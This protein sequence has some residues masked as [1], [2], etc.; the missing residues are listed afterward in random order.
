[1]ASGLKVVARAAT[2]ALSAFLEVPAI[3]AKLAVASA[4]NVVARAA[5]EALSALLA[6]PAVKANEAV[7]V[8]AKA[9]ALVATEAVTSTVSGRFNVTLTSV[10]TFVTAVVILS[11]VPK[12]CKSSAIKSTVCVPVSPSTVKLV[13]NPVN[14]EPSPSN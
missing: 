2:E 1:M 14:P 10:P 7:A 4:L 8:G 6:V 3:K 5:T 12:I 13:A 9:F 11:V